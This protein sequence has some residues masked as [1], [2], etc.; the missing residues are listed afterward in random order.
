MVGKLYIYAGDNPRERSKLGQGSRAHFWCWASL[1]G[2]SSQGK[3]L[4]TTEKRRCCMWSALEKHG[5]AMF[6]RTIP[7][8]T[9]E[10]LTH[11]KV[12]YPRLRTL[13]KRSKLPYDL[14][15]DEDVSVTCRRMRLS[16][17]W[18]PPKTLTRLPRNMS[19]CTLRYTIRYL[20]LTG[21]H[22]AAKAQCGN[23]WV[24][25]NLLHFS[26]AHYPALL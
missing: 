4:S 1:K 5:Y 20:N 8:G 19:T 18:F 3:K 10:S 24:I 21:I 2:L 15:E 11:F 26:L 17:S 16:L 22:L 7:G 23:Q 14:F 13:E 25:C 9:A 6:S 12:D